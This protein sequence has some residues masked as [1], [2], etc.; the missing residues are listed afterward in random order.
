MNGALRM[1]VGVIAAT[2][3]ALGCD[4]GPTTPGT[5]DPVDGMITAI[6]IDDFDGDPIFLVEEQPDKADEGQKML[7]HLS[8]ETEIVVILPSGPEVLGG[9][10]D[11]VVGTRVRAWKGPI[12]T[13]S[14]PG[15]TTAPRIE[16]IR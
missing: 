1:A 11:L 9:V 3:F 14:Y 4:D 15:G 10:A 5:D 13:D 8:E 6:V 2:G 16:V 12:I 7:F